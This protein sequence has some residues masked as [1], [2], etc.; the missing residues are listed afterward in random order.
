M[1]NVDQSA[2]VRKTE[3]RSE[4]IE[5]AF[6][7][8]VDH[9]EAGSTPRNVADL[10]A[11][12][13]AAYADELQSMLAM[14]GMLNSVTDDSTSILKSRGSSPIADEQ[15]ETSTPHQIG[16]YRILQEVGRGGMGVVYEAEQLS[17]G[18][19]VALKVLPFASLSDPHHR[20]R[21]KNEARAAANVVHP[22]IVPVFATGEER[23]VHY[24]AMHFIDGRALD[25]VIRTHQSHSNQPAQAASPAS[26]VATDSTQ[27]ATQEPTLHWSTLR[28]SNAKKFYQV[29]A[30]IGQQLADALAE[31]HRCGV[32][33]RDIKP[34]NILIDGDGKPWLTDFGLAQLSNESRITKTGDMLGAMRYM[35][36]E[37]AGANAV[38]LDHRT[39][40]YSLGATL[41]ELIALRAAHNSED[42]IKLLREVQDRDP[43]SLYSLNR[44]A[45]RALITIVHKALQ[46]DPALRYATAKEMSEDLQRFSNGDKIHARPPTLT[47]R[48][49]GWVRQNRVVVACGT[50][51]VLVSL[52]LGLLMQKQHAESLATANQQLDFRYSR[53]KEDLSSAMR[54]FDHVIIPLVHRDVISEREY[55]SVEQAVEIYQEIANRHRRDPGFMPEATLAYLNVGLIHKRFGKRELS[56]D[57]VQNAV[58]IAREYVEKRPGFEAESGL[59]NALSFLGVTAYYFDES[60]LCREASAEVERRSRMLLANST[61]DTSNVLSTFVQSTLTQLLVQGDAS[62]SK[63]TLQSLRIRLD[64]IDKLREQTNLPDHGMEAVTGGVFSVAQVIPDEWRDVIESH[65]G[66]EFELPDDEPPESGSDLIMD[67]A[68]AVLS[69][70][71]TIGNAIENVE[72]KGETDER[73]E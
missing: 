10:I 41:Y 71:R 27:D 38:P 24:M 32:I 63:S 73:R 67:G 46:K 70:L 51:T 2:R 60:V 16:D 59:V 56:L 25:Y 19:R 58:T 5:D 40:I 62:N 54:A 64:E 47:Q 50:V 42:R 45:P 23:G 61:H 29:V 7:D 28:I 66:P 37:Q 17:L 1:T 33:H 12:K 14:V 26:T 69:A 65:F 44:D 3:Q 49:R 15:I 53:A 34:S 52:C 4:S 13:Y 72:S 11:E 57:A 36:P 9:I 8:L 30:G 18:R 6:A 31:A 22:N 35:S 20:I 68:S 39:D 43:P 48:L 21:F 55:E